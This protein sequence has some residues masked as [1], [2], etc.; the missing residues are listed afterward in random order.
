MLSVAAADMNQK[1]LTTL[2]G[3]GQMPDIAVCEAS[4]GGMLMNQDIWEDITKAPYN[5]S[6]ADVLDHLI[7]LESSE[8][9]KWIG[10]GGW[11]GGGLA[12]KRNLTKEYF[13][14][15]DPQELEKIFSTW[16]A[17]FKAGQEV[18]RKSG[19]KVFMLSSLGL[20]AVMFRGQDA[21]PFIINKK[22][23]LEKSMQPI[24]EQLIDLKR[25]NISDLIENGSP[26]E[27][28]SY[29]TDSH[30]FYPC[31][32][33]SVVFTIKANDRNSMGRWGFMLPPG[34]AF[35]WGGSVFAVPK[36]AKN[37][38]DAVDYIRFF[39]GSIEGAV[40]N[41]ALG[42][43]SPYKPVYQQADF[44]SDPDPYFAG[45]DWMKEMAQRVIPA[46]QKVRVP[47]RYD[48]GIA[49]VLNLAI[50][51]INASTGNNITA[52]QIIEQMKVE[53]ISK[54]PELTR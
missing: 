44:Y 47:S 5:F 18:Q 36:G 52:A 41:R 46:I 40:I 22:L 45:Q 51:S 38:T 49:D 26:E 31:A 11:G 24:L 17:F 29:A 32:N 53:L 43:F 16:D 8:D 33:F 3:G 39:Y 50:K 9:G 23:N 35:P 25:Y 20:A 34:G 7:P 27:G 28:A 1:L 10:P 15:D 54:Y 13:G 48:Q 21:E 2:A 14:T 6:K 30:I 12:Y 4:Y 37:K 42:N 19:G